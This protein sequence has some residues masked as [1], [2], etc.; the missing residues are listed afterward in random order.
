MYSVATDMSKYDRVQELCK[1][2][3]VRS[4]LCYGVRQTLLRLLE[5]IE[6]SGS[7]FQEHVTVFY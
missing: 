3:S 2:A 7:K 4:Y 6:L 5:V 1:Q